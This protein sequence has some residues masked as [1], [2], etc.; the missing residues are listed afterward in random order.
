MKRIITT[1]ALLI[2]SLFI[3]N[4]QSEA[5]S[6][7]VSLTADILPSLAIMT[8]PSTVSFGALIAGNV[9]QGNGA[10]DIIVGTNSA[11]GY[12][13]T[14]SD[15]QPEGDSC[16]ANQSDPNAKIGDFPASI[17]APKIYEPGDKGLAFT[18][19]AADTNKEGVWGT[20]NTFNSSLNKYAGIPQNSTVFHQS[21]GYKSINDHTSI[22][23]LLDVPSSQQS[24]SYAGSI[25]L[26][27]TCMLN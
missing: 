19:F 18:M 10:I 12:F 15:E 5:E 2:G 22:S 8:D 17:E 7:S 3:A 27:A 1:I 6:A 26:S 9:S 23:F 11:N 4:Q 25:V 21:P 24:G 16:M 20:G 13:L 14:I